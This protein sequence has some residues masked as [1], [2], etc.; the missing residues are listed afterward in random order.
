MTAHICTTTASTIDMT[1]IIFGSFFLLY[2]GAIIGAAITKRQYQKTFSNAY[3]NDD[4]K[5]S[6]DRITSITNPVHIDNKLQDK[7]NGK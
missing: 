5:K 2:I 6:V 7:L 4:L 1:L 3:Q